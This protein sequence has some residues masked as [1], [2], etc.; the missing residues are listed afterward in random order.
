MSAQGAPVCVSLLSA[1]VRFI[2]PGTQPGTHPGIEF[3]PTGPHGR[4]R[5]KGPDGGHGAHNGAS[6]VG[7]G[8]GFFVGVRFEIEPGLDVVGKC[9]NHPDSHHFMRVRKETKDLSEHYRTEIG[10]ETREE[11]I[12]GDRR[13]R[14]RDIALLRRQ[15]RG[16][17]RDRGGETRQREEMRERIQERLKRR[18]ETRERK[19]R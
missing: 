5:P 2:H 18:T 17:N 14:G 7:V 19:K 13:E 15:E 6:G 11:R 3:R 12:W 10:R 8:I 4:C 16:Y 1:V 9:P